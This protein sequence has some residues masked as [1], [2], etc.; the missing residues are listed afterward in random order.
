MLPTGTDGF[1]NAIFIYDDKQVNITC[2]KVG[3]SVITSEIMGLYGSIKIGSISRFDDAV[4][5][6]EDGT[7]E[8]LV[9]IF[10]G[11]ELMKNE[12]EAFYRYN[13]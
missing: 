7:E 3:S 12:A 13:R 8:R 10:T 2:S 6:K 1:D 9:E 11:A 5:V 4:L